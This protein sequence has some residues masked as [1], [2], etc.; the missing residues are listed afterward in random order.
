M[1]KKALILFK[2]KWDWDKFIISK[3]SN[4]YEVK[5]LYLD[6]VKKNYLNTISQVNN[7][8]IDNKIDTVF[9]D[10]DYQKFVNYY[11]INKIKNVK[12][13]MMTL[14]NYERHNLNLITACSCHVVL[15]DPISLLKYKE[16][17]IPAYNWLI[18]SDGS[19]YKDMALEKKT[20]VLFFGKINKDRKNF[21]E[22]IENNG[23]KVKVVGNNIESYISDKELINLICESKI[24]I[25]FS[26]TTWEKISNYPEKSIFKNQYQ[27]KGRIIQ[28]G[29]CG[30]ACITEYAPQHKLLYKEDE[31][32]QFTTKEECVKI[33]NDLLNNNNKLLNYT[34][35]FSTKTQEEY[36]DKKFFKK[37]YYFL[38]EI[39]P[40]IIKTDKNLRIIPYWY[41]RI[42]CKQILLRDLKISKFFQSIYNFKEISSIAKKSNIFTFL[43]ISIETAVNLIYYSLLNSIKRKTV[44]KNR[45]TDEL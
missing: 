14:D 36:E 43:L 29:L 32:L 18:E 4:F 33:L 3:I 6:Q 30:T 25:N 24:V 27:L 26:K 17:G 39:D 31:L 15:T 20:D 34:K 45:Y 21:V 2:A 37:I 42:C 28:A 8:I 44:G 22:F 35:K 38:E 9:F 23:I 13:V 12:K 41:K 7:F 19:I 16:L 10:V 11:F 5:F 40:N 1:K